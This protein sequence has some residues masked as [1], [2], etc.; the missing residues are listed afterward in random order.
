MLNYFGQREALEW[1]LKTVLK[2]DKEKSGFGRKFLLERGE[3]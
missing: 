3:D 1:R 2:E